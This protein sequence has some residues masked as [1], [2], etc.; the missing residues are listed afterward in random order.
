MPITHRLLAVCVAVLW[1]FNFLAI[2]ASLEH[3]PPFFLVALRWTLLAIP[4]ILLIPR[5]QV[6][7]RWLVGYGLGFG[8]L[9]FTFLYWAMSAGMPVGL[10]SLVLQ[11]SA[12]FTVLLGAFFLRE[13]LTPLR[14]VGVLVAVGGLAVVGSQRFAGATWVPFL[15][16]VAAG[17]GWAIGNVCSRRAGAPSPFHLTM[18]MTVIPPLPMLALA[19]AVEG[20]ARIGDSLATAFTAEAMPALVG[21]LY[22]VL[23]A[24]VL[25][26]G[27]W[28][29]LMGRHPAG[30]VAPFSMLV[31][32]TGLTVAWLVLNERPSGIELLGC[33]IVVAGVLLGSLRTF[34]VPPTPRSDRGAAATAGRSDPP[35]GQPRSRWTRD[36][37][38]TSGVSPTRSSTWPREPWS[39]NSLGMP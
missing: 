21:L 28:T 10:A 17:F 39:R 24:T 34:P 38:I 18:W 14:V 3:F 11:A 13:H 26:S 15:L 32:V 8:V 19:L 31:P 23:P 22:T 1:G 33:V 4:T 12:P 20:P 35:P 7:L 9:Q 27:I 25:G 5:P 6:P 2:H 29:W 30:V 36:V 37:A 16:T